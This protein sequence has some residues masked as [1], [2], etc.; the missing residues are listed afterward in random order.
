MKSWPEKDFAKLEIV[1]VI[2]HAENYPKPAFSKAKNE[3]NGLHTT[4]LVLPGLLLTDALP[5]PSVLD[6][7]LK[8][9]GRSRRFKTY[10][11]SYGGRSL[12]PFLR[13]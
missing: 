1:F 13:P 3:F 6:G 7:R 12:R 11:Y 8:F 10:G 4:S 5:W 2:C 9:Y